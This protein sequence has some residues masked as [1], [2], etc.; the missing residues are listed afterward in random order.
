MSVSKRFKLPIKS[1]WFFRGVMYGYPVCCIENFHTPPRR[2]FQS[3]QESVA[4][5]GFG[6]C[7]YHASLRPDRVLEE[8]YQVRSKLATRSTT[9]SWAH[10]ATEQRREKRFAYRLAKLKAKE[11]KR[12]KRRFKTDADF[13]EWYYR[14]LREER[15]HD[16]HTR[17][18]A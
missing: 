8:V 9:E 5:L 2:K 3:S 17:A 14:H 16:H 6:V 15:C 1:T 7:L 10:W 12:S 11:E 18:V 4:A 13:A